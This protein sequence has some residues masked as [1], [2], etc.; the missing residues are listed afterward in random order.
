MDGLY[1]EGFS[2]YSAFGAELTST[3][4]GSG[5]RIT[6]SREEAKALLQVSK[7]RF[8]RRV[9]SVSPR[10]GKVREF[11]L[12]YGLVMSVTDKEGRELVPRQ[13]LEEVRDFVFDETDVLGKSSEQALL[14]EEMQRDLIQQI[15]RRLQA[16]AG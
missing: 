9:L 1:V 5:V 6:E 14:R 4:E 15:L 3:L 10:T 2:E 16:V 12:H 7:V 8:H 11:E 13:R